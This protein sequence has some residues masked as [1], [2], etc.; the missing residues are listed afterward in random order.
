[1]Q[2]NRCTSCGFVILKSALHDPYLCRDC[3]YLMLE[4]DE[5]YAYLDK[6]WGVMNVNY[7]KPSEEYDFEDF[8]SR[9]D[10]DNYTDLMHEFEDK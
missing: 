1:M 2:R 6:T 9:Y 5:R 7:K 10:L 4:T 8:F 3:E